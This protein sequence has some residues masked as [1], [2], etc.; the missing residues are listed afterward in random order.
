ML[1]RPGVAAFLRRLAAASAPDGWSRFVMLR[2]GGRPLAW[3]FA[4]AHGPDGYY[5]TPGYDP[6]ADDLSPGMLLIARLVEHG[7]ACGWR[8]LHF[9]TGGHPYKLSWT[10]DGQTRWAVRWQAPTWR[11]RVLGWYDRRRAAPESPR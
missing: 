6:A 9:L 8:R 10:R 1:R 11:G 2:V 4:L 7:V 3:L 5:L